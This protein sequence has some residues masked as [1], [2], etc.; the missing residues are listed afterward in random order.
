MRACRNRDRTVTRQGPAPAGAVTPAPRVPARPKGRSQP[1]L[2]AK[3]PI[4]VDCVL[5]RPLPS[6]GGR[7]SVESVAEW[8]WNTQRRKPRKAAAP[9]YPDKTEQGPGR[10]HTRLPLEIKIAVLVNMS[11][12]TQPRSAGM[13]S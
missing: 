12:L 8:T 2:E 9:I 13:H 1:E 5:R 10:D 11:V 7:I 4:L 3:G 6:G